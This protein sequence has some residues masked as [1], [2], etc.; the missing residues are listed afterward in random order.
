MVIEVFAGSA[1][2][3]KAFSS[4]GTQ[5]VAVDTKDASQIKIVKLNLLRKG[6]VDLVY[7]LLQ[8]RNVIMVHMAPP[9]STS[10]QARRIQRSPRDPK[11]LRSWCMPD[12]LAG[13]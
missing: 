4:V 6:S 1:N 8:T 12:G 10:S 7:R 9:C 11:P 2:L 13:L 5:V 3:S